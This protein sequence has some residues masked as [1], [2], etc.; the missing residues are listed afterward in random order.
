[1]NN[2]DAIYEVDRDD[3]VGFVSQLNK[4]KCYVSESTT[5]ESSTVYEIY[6]KA[7]DN[8]LCYRVIPKDTQERYYVVNMPAD[9]ERI[10]P[11]PVRTVTLDTREAVEEFLNA[12]GHIQKG[13][14]KHD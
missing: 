10:P 1:M 8:L 13:D 3:Y 14:Y 5:D 12:L 2:P 11:K 4:T 9:D 6:S 7:S